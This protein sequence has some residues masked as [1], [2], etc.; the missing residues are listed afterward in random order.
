MSFPF[1]IPFCCSTN[2]ILS[3]RIRSAFL[4]LFTYSKWYNKLQVNVE[5]HCPW[6]FVAVEWSESKLYNI[7]QLVTISTILNDIRK[8]T[9][10]LTAPILHKLIPYPGLLSEIFHC[11][12]C[13]CLLQKNVSTLMWIN[14]RGSLSF[15][16]IWGTT[17]VMRF[18]IYLSKLATV[19]LVSFPYKA[20]YVCMQWFVQC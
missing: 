17:H 13:M 2:L 10:S 3:H 1:I 11:C 16:A 8:Q 12:R 6:Y 4:C 19:I 20:S 9:T 18:N 5:K 14:D 7:L 15:R